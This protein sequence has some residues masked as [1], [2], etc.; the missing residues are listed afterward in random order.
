VFSEQAKDRRSTVSLVGTVEDWSYQV[1]RHRRQ[2]LNNAPSS[3]VQLE[4]VLDDILIVSDILVS[5]YYST[6]TLERLLEVKTNESSPATF[7]P[8]YNR[9]SKLIPLRIYLSNYQEINFCPSY[10]L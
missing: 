1:G 3:P 7:D 2:I 10:Y 5:R 9:F 4:G 6:L 8:I